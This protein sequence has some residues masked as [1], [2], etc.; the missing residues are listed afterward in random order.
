MGKK[1]KTLV[2]I[3]SVLTLLVILFFVAKMVVTDKIENSIDE[4]LGDDSG[5]EELDVNLLQQ[6]ISMKGL[7]Y[8]KRGNTV[9]ADRISMSGIGF[10]RYLTQDKLHI[11]NLTFENPQIII[12]PADSTSTK[13]SEEKFSRDISIGRISATNGTLKHRNKGSKGNKIFFRFPEVMLSRVTIDSSTVKNKIPL[14]YENYLIR[15][16]SLR[17]NLN[18]E[19]FVAANHV[20]IEDGHTLVKNFR[21][22]P[23]YDKSDFDRKIPYEKDRISLRVERVEMDSLSFW[24]RNSELYLRNPKMTV[25][26]GDLQVYRNRVL[27]DDPRERVLYSQLLRNA[28]VKLDFPKVIVQNSHIG[29]EEKM[30]DQRP[31]ASV[32]FKIKQ[33]EIQN[34]TNIN[35]DRKDF[36]RTKVHVEATFQEV[37][38]LSVDWSFNTSNPNDKFFFQGKFGAVPGDALN[39]LLRPSMSMEAKGTIKD[40][41][42]TFTGNDEV[43]TGDV[44]LNYDQFKFVLLKNGSR[45]KKG[46]LTALANLLVD[47]N[48]LSGENA[49]KD[50]TVQRDVHVS[51]WG[52]VWSGLREGVRQ[53]FKQI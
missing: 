53:T 38:P 1:K 51:F 5:Y 37:A 19:H 24:F 46:I 29:Y 31:P 33:A 28:P 15:G 44:R 12:G 14:N 20:R 35:L 22:I 39:S 16:D 6:E 32:V 17:L 26:G 42:F 41:W 47:N 18:P 3:L 8:N 30:K 25:S 9:H 7:N 45:E 40:A 50:I 10:F 21:I 4:M 43:L 34:L 27:P 13:K 49:T 23:Y 36:P 52:Y 2:I 48:G 11:D